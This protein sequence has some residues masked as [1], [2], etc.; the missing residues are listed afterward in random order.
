MSTLLS[1]GQDVQGYNTYAPYTATDKY[2]S[3]LT[4]GSATSITVP[5]NHAVWIAVFSYQPGASVWVNLTG[6]TA[7]VPAGA[8][9]AATTSELNPGAR[10]V[11]KGTTISMI[12]GDTSANVGVSLYAISYP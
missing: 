4:T 6:A 12:T 1:F 5:S 8:T 10:M 2:S 3:T 11:N 7:A 9:L